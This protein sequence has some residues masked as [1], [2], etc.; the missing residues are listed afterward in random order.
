MGNNA[1]RPSRLELWLLL[2]AMVLSVAWSSAIA[3]TVFDCVAPAPPVLVSPIVLGDG[4]AGSV[5]TAQLQAAFNTASAVRLNIGSNTLTLDQELLINRAVILDANGATL[6]GGNAHR[7][8]HISNPNNLTYTFSLLNA[9]IANAVTSTQSGAGLWKPSVSEAWQVVTIR[10]FNSHF[11]NNTAI[12]VAQDDGGGGIYV[13]GAKE[14]TVVNSTFSGNKGANGGAVYSLGSQLVDLFDTQ[15]SGNS[16]TGTGG[17]PGS[18]GNGGAIGV[19]GDA[20]NVNLC[21]VTV[22]GNT[23]NAFGA[24]FFTTSYS[25]T[26]FTRIQDSTFQGNQSVATDKLVGGAYLQGTTFSIRGSTFQNNVAGGYAGVALFDETTDSGVVHTTGDITNSTFVGNQAINGLGG[27]MAIQA[28]GAVTLEN[29]T[30]ANNTSTCNGVCFAGGIANDADSPITMR[31]TIFLNNTGDN[32]FNPWALLHPVSGSNNIQWPKIRPGGQQESPVTTGAL[33][34]DALLLP[35][36]SNG[37]LT[38][39]MALPAN[40]PAVDAGTSLG[41]LPT[42]QRGYP[43]FGPVDVGAFEFE[44]HIFSDGFQ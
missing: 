1:M 12:A 29:L 22:S 23:S 11:V 33:F 8:L 26:S 19:D 27:A 32:A 40:S 14:L 13:V 25:T 44:D 28:T 5:T 41:S 21:R 35:V 7:V 4:S 43:R 30:I 10:I 20:R 2:T 31:N 6:S 3:Q 37:G 42:D 39:T 9:T 38:Q 17:N 15:L 34:A 24:G 16:A 18:G 36:A